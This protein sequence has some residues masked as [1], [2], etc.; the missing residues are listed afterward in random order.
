MF[1]HTPSTPPPTKPPVTIWVPGTRVSA[2]LPARI[3]PKI[4]QN[5]MAVSSCP[6]G[7]KLSTEVDPFYHAHRIGTLLSQA[8]PQQFPLK[9]FYVFGWSGELDH[10]ARLQGGATLYQELKKLLTSYKTMYGSRPPLTIIT[11]SHGGN[12]ALNMV[13]VTNDNDDILVDRLILLACPVQKDTTPFIEHPLF[14]KIYSLHSD[15]DLVQVLDPQGIHPFKNAIKKVFETKSFDP[16]KRAYNELRQR[17]FFSHRHFPAH[18]KLIQADIAWATIIPWTSEDIAIFP[19]PES[20][21]IKGI[22]QLQ[23][24]HKLIHIE[25][26]LPSFFKQLPRILVYVDQQAGTPKNQ[27]DIAVGI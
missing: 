2:F 13:H 17:P 26:L 4:K 5:E 12:V 11:H 19:Y 23:R 1:I 22:K 3:G 7:L 25:F 21:L 24:P 18:E 8:D 10:Q 16:I 27:A 20:M 6:P 15:A 9:T 14:N